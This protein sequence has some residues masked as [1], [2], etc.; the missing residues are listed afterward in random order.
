MEKERGI[1]IVGSGD[2]TDKITKEKISEMQ[3]MVA[4]DIQ[5]QTDFSKP[6][7]LINPHKNFSYPLYEYPLEKVGNSKWLNKS[8]KR[9]KTKSKQAKKSRKLNRKNK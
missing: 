8:K 5:N 4:M 9:N 2:Q 3:E 7:P 1:V 6:I